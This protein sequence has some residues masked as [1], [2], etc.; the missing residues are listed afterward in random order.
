MVFHVNE[1]LMKKVYTDEYWHLV[2]VYVFIYTHFFFT[3][4]LYGTTLNYPASSLKGP[5]A[6]NVSSYINSCAESGV[7]EY[8][9]CLNPLYWKILVSYNF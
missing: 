1:C 7:C 8:S 3:S 2:K 5:F 9:M 4:L 6:D